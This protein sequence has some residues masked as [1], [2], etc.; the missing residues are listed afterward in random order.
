MLFALLFCFRV[1]IMCTAVSTFCFQMLSPL[2]DPMINNIGRCLLTETPSLRWLWSGLY[3][4]PIL[5]FT[6]FNNSLVMGGL[7]F[8]LFLALPVYAL[9]H[10]MLRKYGER[11]AERLRDTNIWRTVSATKLIRLYVQ[12]QHAPK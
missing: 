2:L 11:T 12:Y 1:N 3:H 6:R 10:F 7:A 5:P 8:C 4:C 9:S